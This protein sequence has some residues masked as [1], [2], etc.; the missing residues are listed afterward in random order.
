M[1]Q[2]KNRKYEAIRIRQGKNR[3][4]EQARNHKKTWKFWEALAVAVRTGVH[5]GFLSFAA[6]TEDL[7]G[8]QPLGEQHSTG[9]VEATKGRRYSLFLDSPHI[10]HEHTLAQK[11]SHVSVCG[12]AIIEVPSKAASDE[13]PEH[14][15]IG[16]VNVILPDNVARETITGH[17]LLKVVLSVAADGTAE[18]ITVVNEEKTQ[19]FLLI[20]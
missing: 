9:F 17:A 6:E 7:G 8:R 14:V 5:E 1:R 16:E 3:K 15:Y 11:I 4:K 20:E 10:T 19:D 18:R 2:G 12:T 13:E